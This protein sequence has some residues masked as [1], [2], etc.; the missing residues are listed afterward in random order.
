MKFIKNTNLVDFN[1]WGGAQY[2][3]FT[4]KDLIEL[5]EALGEEFPNG[6]DETTLNDMFWFEEHYL[7]ELTT[8]S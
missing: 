7:C 6:L 3:N 1:F 4:E 2:H 8:R 5:D